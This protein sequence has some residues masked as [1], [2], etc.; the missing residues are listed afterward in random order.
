MP[1]SMPGSMSGPVRPRRSGPPRRYCRSMS[2]GRPPGQRR[3][4][5][6]RAGSSAAFLT[7]DHR[8]RPRDP[9]RDGRHDGPTGGDRHGVTATDRVATRTRARPPAC[10]LDRRA[11]PDRTIG[12][13]RSTEDPR[14][15]RR[16]PAG[17]NGRST[18][19]PAPAQPGAVGTWVRPGHRGVPSLR[20]R[21]QGDA[22]SCGHRRDRHR[23]QDRCSSPA[24]F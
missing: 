1:G 17:T 3:G 23:P 21:P 6:V 22:R 5:G 15:G 10:A 12:R 4:V 19:R 18:P 8:R 20:A 11:N 14:P 16:P 2:R 7:G 9:R 24:C 13:P